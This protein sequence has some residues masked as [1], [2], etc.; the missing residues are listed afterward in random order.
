VYVYHYAC[1]V[2]NMKL[3]EEAGD[4]E[5][6]RFMLTDKSPGADLVLVCH[7]HNEELRQTWMTHINSLLDMQGHFLRGTGSPRSSSSGSKS[8]SKS[9]LDLV[10]HVP[11]GA[12]GDE[13]FPSGMIAGSLSRVT[14][15]HTHLFQIFF[16]CI[17]P[18]LLKYVRLFMF[19]HS[20]SPDWRQA[21]GRP[22]TTWIHQICRD[23]G[24]SVT[25]ALELAGDR[26]FWRQIATA[27]C[28]G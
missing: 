17:L 3:T 26:S 9:Y 28:Y 14:P 15:V 21:R 18:C 2:N 1:Q 23:M 19:V 13:L 10:P 6:L 12:S 22:L 20:Y 11:G 16:H 4:E 7:A 25:D 8:V 5:Q 24:I 27:G